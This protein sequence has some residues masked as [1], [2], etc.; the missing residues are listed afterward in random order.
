[1]PNRSTTNNGSPE[2]RPSDVTSESRKAIRKVPMAPPARRWHPKTHTAQ[3]VRIE[4]R[5]DLSGACPNRARCGRA[6]GCRSCFRGSVAGS[7]CRKAAVTELQAP[8]LPLPGSHV[9]RAGA[10][11]H[12]L[13][14]HGRA[15][16]TPC[17]ILRKTWGRR[18]SR[19]FSV[20]SRHRG[21]RCTCSSLQRTLH[22]Y[23]TLRAGTVVDWVTLRIQW[24]AVSIHT[25]ARAGSVQVTRSQGETTGSD[26]GGCPATPRTVFGGAH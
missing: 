19:Q 20:A 1:M 25:R 24:S 15:P 26:K 10:P 2:S 13:E 21:G 18:E 17:K 11:L 8:H 14:P 9:W 23:T 12:G 3:P 5:W 22:F 6:W 4:D 7:R 16:E